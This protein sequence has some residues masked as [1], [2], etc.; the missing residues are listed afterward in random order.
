MCSEDDEDWVYDCSVHQ[1][2]LRHSDSVIICLSADLF[3]CEN[4]TRYV[5]GLRKHFDPM[6]AI[7][8]LS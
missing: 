5:H 2:R 7:D 4:R 3:Y 8:R 6:P 1:A